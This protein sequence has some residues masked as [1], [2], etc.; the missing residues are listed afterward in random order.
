MRAGFISIAHH[1]ENDD[2]AVFWQGLIEENVIFPQTKMLLQ[3]PKIVYRPKYQRV[4]L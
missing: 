3:R 2:F 1:V 4:F